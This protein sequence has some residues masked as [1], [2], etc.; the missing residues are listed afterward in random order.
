[1]KEPEE[2]II[3]QRDESVVV[4]DGK[5]TWAGRWRERLI[6]IVL[7][8]EMI[9]SITIFHA[10]LEYVW[11][12]DANDEP[13][14]CNGS[15]DEE[16]FE[17]PFGH[18]NEEFSSYRTCFVSLSFNEQ[19]MIDV[20]EYHETAKID[21]CFLKRNEEGSLLWLGQAKWVLAKDDANY[22]IYMPDQIA[23]QAACDPV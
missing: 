17:C 6:E 22:L 14:R 8:A 21:P 10:E 13:C 20:A 19:G 15:Y 18:Y 16:K 11:P 2:V 12:C 1:M 9:S 7:D 23:L 3:F 4:E 5:E